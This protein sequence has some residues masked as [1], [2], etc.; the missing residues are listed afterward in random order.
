MALP[1]LSTQPKKRHQVVAIDLG[2]R[3]TKAVF[4]QRKGEGY[5]FVQYALL[6]APVFD[7]TLS[8]ETLGEHLKGVC[9]A[10]GGRIK[11]V[12]LVIGVNDSLLRHAEL[13]M[14]PVGDMCLMLKYNSKSYLQQD[15]PDYIFDCYILPRPAGAPVEPGKPGQ[16]CRVLVGGAKKQVIDNLQE[17]TKLAGLAVDQISPSLIATAN[18]FEMAQPEVFGKEVVALVDI[19]F[20]NSTISILLNGELDLSRVVGIGGDKLTS[21][22]AEAMGINYAEAEGIKIGLPDEVQM[23][24]QSLLM[25]LG[26]EL[27]AS[28]DFF[29]HQQDK[30]VGQVFISGGS[31]RS[32]F[33]IDTLQ[34]EMMVPCK[35]WN[36]AGFLT[37]A[38]AP[39][40]LAEWEQV[41]PQLTIAIGGAMAAF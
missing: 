7:K 8:A 13:P 3:T 34:S 33:I 1:F 29:E 31:A 9:Q 20:K 17:A 14:V 16:K 22:L 35:S 24:M 10:L 4:L 30:S 27:R 19:G 5:E 12:V 21:G 40:Q 26:R 39:Q 38:L 37:L 28:I 11:Q 25:P 6:D 32:Q 36:P 2:M 41:A 18:A 15:L 23:V